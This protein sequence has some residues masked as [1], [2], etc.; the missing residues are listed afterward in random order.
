MFW[1]KNKIVEPEKEDNKLIFSIKDGKLSIALDIY[2][3]NT[4]TAME[5]GKLLYSINSGD[6]EEPI[7]NMLVE[8]ASKDTGLNNFIEEVIK[9]WIINKNLKS[10]E[11]YISPLKVFQQ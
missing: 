9:Y 8:L 10:D 7:A 11:P 2:E 6:L 4:S 1:P 5:V 3:D